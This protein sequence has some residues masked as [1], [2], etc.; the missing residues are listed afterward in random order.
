MQ[1]VK[2]IDVTTELIREN[3]NKFTIECFYKKVC[4]KTKVIYS[5]FAK[6]HHSKLTTRIFSSLQFD[7][8]LN[9]GMELQVLDMRHE[10]YN[11]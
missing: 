1:K 4:Q 6:H 10:P 2:V 8:F 3:N 5:S 11:I 9:F 7:K